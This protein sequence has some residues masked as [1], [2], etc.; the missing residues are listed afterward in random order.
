MTTSATV[1]QTRLCSIEDF[2]G[3]GD[4]RFFARGF[5]RATHQVYDIVA[6]A[7]DAAEPGVRATADLSYPADWSTKQDDTDLRPHLATTD[8]LIL[9]VQLA[10]IHLTHAYGLTPAERGASR[11]RKVV[12]RAGTQ[13]LED[14]DGVVL[15]AALRSTA[16][17]CDG[18]DEFVSVF[19]CSVGPLKV[20][21]EI[22]HPINERA[23]AEASFD[24]LDHVLGAGATRL[25]GEG[26]KTRR[27]AI[28][29]VDV[30]MAELVAQAAVH[31]TS[32]PDSPALTEGIE[33]SVDPSVSMVECFVVNLQLAQV[34]MYKMDSVR[35]EDSD[36]LWM[37]QTIIEAPRTPR[38]IDGPLA[39]RA[40]I[41]KKHLLPLRGG[42]WR[43]VDIAGHMS[44]IDLRCSFAHEL[45]E[46]AALKAV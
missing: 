13:P 7:A 30:D 18:A 46:E 37:M 16:E 31:L 15:A 19:D 14:L 27:H 1:E 22:E 40:A 41:V 44:G 9:G 28:Q 20:R 12:M 2:L 4:N 35:R 36:N 43:S 42:L 3:P 8:A 11:L 39:A 45:P 32:V 21:C 17:L 34:L 23:E 29:D 26:F 38:P 24:S 25:Y 6:S 5:Q 33:G 10:E